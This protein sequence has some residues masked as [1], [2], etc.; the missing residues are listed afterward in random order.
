MRYSITMLCWLYYEKGD[1]VIFGY[2]DISS[3]NR[4]IVLKV[5]DRKISLLFRTQNHS[6]ETT[7]TA[8][9]QL[10]G[11]WKF[12]GASYDHDSG[13]A[14]LWVDGD[15]AMI[16]TVREGHELATQDS[17]IMGQNVEGKITQLQIY[18]LPLTQEQ[19]QII[20]KR[21]QLPGL[22][23]R[24]FLTTVSVNNSGT[25]DTSEDDTPFPVQCCTNRWR[26]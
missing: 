19:I 10:A 11:G 6:S 12:V 26:F 22:N 3:A 16:E 15:V 8:N 17:I 7:L 25:F 4:G 23:I 14:K 2:G 24:L 20:Q 21:T 5:K 13:E 9:T 1:G 18:N